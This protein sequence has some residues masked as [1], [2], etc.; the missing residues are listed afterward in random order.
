[1]AKYLKAIVGLHHPIQATGADQA[2]LDVAIKLSIPH[3]G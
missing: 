1:M 3:D 2:T